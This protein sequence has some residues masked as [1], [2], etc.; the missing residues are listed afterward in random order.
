MPKKETSNDI[1]GTVHVC[2]QPRKKQERVTNGRSYGTSVTKHA[3]RTIDGSPF[4]DWAKK[5]EK[6]AIDPAKIAALTVLTRPPK[7]LAIT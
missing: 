6:H 2:R 5:K 3:G 4:P 1:T 7:K